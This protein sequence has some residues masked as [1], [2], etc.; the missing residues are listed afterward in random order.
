MA[1]EHFTEKLNILRVDLFR[2]RNQDC[3]M[4]KGMKY[5]NLVGWE[6]LV[7]LATLLIP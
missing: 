3:Q 5:F 2:E 6:T 1:R 7:I 4:G